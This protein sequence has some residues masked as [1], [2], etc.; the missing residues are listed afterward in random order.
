MPCMY[1][2]QNYYSIACDYEL[3][4]LIIES[5]PCTHLS[6]SVY[7]LTN[8][9]QCIRIHHDTVGGCNIS[10]GAWRSTN[11]LLMSGLPNYYSLHFLIRQRLFFSWY[12][13]LCVM[14]C[15]LSDT[16]VFVGAT[17]GCRVKINDQ[18]RQRKEQMQI[19]LIVC[20]MFQILI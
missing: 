4:M 17:F 1:L 3:R 12:D 11:M 16:K 14:P 10:Y 8:Q 20:L 13:I 18:W 2:S 9:L 19:Y 5:Y 6:I 15:S 7:T